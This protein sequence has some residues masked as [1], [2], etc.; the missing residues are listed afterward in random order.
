[1]FCLKKKKGR[2]YS[3]NNELMLETRDLFI[4]SDGEKEVLLGQKHFSGPR[5]IIHCLGTPL[6]LEG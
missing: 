5:T 1:M 4:Q 3:I 2:N 6:Q